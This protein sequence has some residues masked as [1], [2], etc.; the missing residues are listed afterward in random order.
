VRLE[1]QQFVAQYMGEN[2]AESLT[3]PPRIVSAA[4]CRARL[5]AANT[6]YIFTNKHTNNY[7]L[8]GTSAS[9]ISL[10]TGAKTVTL[11]VGDATDV[12]VGDILFWPMLAVAP[13]TAV[14][15]VPALRVTS[16]A[17]LVLTCAMLWDPAL[18]NATYPHAGVLIA[19]YETAPGMA[20]TGTTANNSTS[21]TLVTP[22]TFFK[23]GDW[24]TGNGLHAN[25]RVVSG[26]G[27]ATLVLNR[28]ATATASNVK[29]SSAKLQV[30][31]MTDAF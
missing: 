14:A 16:K 26:E 19:V 24:I 18:Y 21:V 17:G 25:A 7:R 5:R 8:V 13:S 3:M 29:L 23:N 10:N 2:G 22:V 6:Q 30:L 9:S 1:G 15:T 27:L 31:T 11:T 28:V 4:R 12:L 20:V